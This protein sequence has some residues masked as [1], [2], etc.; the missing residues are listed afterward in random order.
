MNVVPWRGAHPLQ[1]FERPAFAAPTL[2]SFAVVQLYESAVAESK[3]Y[4]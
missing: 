1:Q 3:M 4:A 2:G